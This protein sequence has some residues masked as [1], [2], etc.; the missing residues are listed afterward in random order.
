MSDDLSQFID[1]QVIRIVRTSTVY[2]HIKKSKCED[3]SDVTL[4]TC[5]GHL[6]CYLKNKYRKK[7]LFTQKTLCDIAKIAA[8]QILQQEQI[9]A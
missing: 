3:F 6:L 4:S 5:A 9:S 1:D 7:Y 8:R 2:K